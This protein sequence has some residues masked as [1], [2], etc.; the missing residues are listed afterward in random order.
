MTTW[1]RVTKAEPCGACLHPDWCTKGEWGWGCMRSE[2][3]FPMA[4]G[5]WFH[6]FSDNPPP[7]KA[8]APQFKSPTIDAHAIWRRWHAE[9]CQEAIDSLAVKLGVSEW[10][11]DA[12][13]AAWAK[14]HAAWAFPMKNGLGDVI[15]IRLRAEDGRKFAVAGS[16]QGIFIPDVEPQDRAFCT[17]GPTDT[18]SAVSLGLFALGR[19]SCNQG[20]LQLHAACRRLGVREVVMVADNDVPG[21]QGAARVAEDIGLPHRTLLCPCKDLR[22]FVRAGGTRLDL[23]NLLRDTKLTC[24]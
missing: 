11:L 13:G 5:G 17:E 12:L 8:L 4:N 24:A 6:P 1:H 21:L 3:K 16:K 20:G 7:R 18:A 9:T 2:S 15:G 14:T 23:E 19:P 22:E 10:S